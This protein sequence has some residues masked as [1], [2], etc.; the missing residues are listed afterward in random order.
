[1]LKSIQIWC[2]IVLLSGAFITSAQQNTAEFIYTKYDDTTS[3]SFLVIA[4]AFTGEEIVLLETEQFIGSLRWSPNKDFIVFDM[5]NDIYLFD[6]DSQD[7]IRL[8]NEPTSRKF[9][10]NW[11]DNN[12]FTYVR[13]EIIDK[14]VVY[15][16]DIMLFDLSSGQS[17]PL[18]DDGKINLDHFWSPNGRYMVYFVT[19][20]AQGTTFTP[21]IY[22]AQTQTSTLLYELILANLRFVSVIWSPDSTRFAFSDIKEMYTF[23][24]TTRQTT[25]V[26]SNREIIPYAWLSNDTLFYGTVFDGFYTV[27]A[28]GTNEQLVSVNMPVLSP[29][30]ISFSSD[31]SISTPTATPTPHAP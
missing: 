30:S 27:Q 16:A 23:D 31:F 18:I 8:T 9:A 14:R 26:T 15:E 2:A 10:F 21:H 4:D 3:K 20:I 6:M 5:A 13:R 17:T 24:L 25:F 11:I 7:T 19:D 28:D 1:M 22:D 29:I 12:K